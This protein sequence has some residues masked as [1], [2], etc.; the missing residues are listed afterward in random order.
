[1]LKKIRQWRR[2]FGIKGTLLI[3]LRP[4]VFV[5]THKRIVAIEPEFD[6]IKKDN[7][8]ALFIF[9]FVLISVEITS[10]L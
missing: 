4:V 1:M 3:L 10:G 8:C 5:V 7:M 9:C 2:D 6:K